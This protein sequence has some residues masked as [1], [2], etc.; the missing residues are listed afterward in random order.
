M[1]CQLCRK[2]PAVIFLNRLE[3][4]QTK[5]FALCMSCARKQGVNM[6]QLFS[7]AGMTEEQAEQLNK[8]LSDALEGTDPRTLQEGLGPLANILPPGML[9]MMTGSTPTGGEDE[10]GD[11]SEEH[12]TDLAGLS[13]DDDESAM[14]Q[15]PGADTD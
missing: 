10:N 5:R 7:S 13:G 8:A 14:Q 2:N 12:V 4:G 3:D 1:L 9:E 6:K 15:G 11:M